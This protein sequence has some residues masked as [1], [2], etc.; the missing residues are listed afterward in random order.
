VAASALPRADAAH[1]FSVYP[2]V[3]LLL[4]AL[5]AKRTGEP[6][7]TPG[8]WAAGGAVAV[9]LALC[10]VLSASYLS[11]LTH[12]ARLERAELWVD[13]ADAWIEPL[14]EYVTQSVP[15]GQPIFVY[16]HEAQLYFLTARFYPWPYSQLY[17]GQEGGDLGFALAELL[18]RFPPRLV[19]R[20]ILGW[21]GTPN[22]QEYA[23]HLGNYLLWKFEND[24]D[25]FV[26][27]PAAS[28]ITPPDWVIGVWRPRPPA[29]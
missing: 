7:A 11:K 4:F 22:L 18:D 5:C 9:L 6:Q 16:G 15:P 8:L 23:P 1:V 29:P 24:V 2:V 13:P 19:L 25:F 20:G 28:G 3:V 26:E 14:V 12:R 21:P 27:H 10:L 17:P